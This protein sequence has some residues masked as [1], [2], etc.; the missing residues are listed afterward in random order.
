MFGN[1]KMWPY[2]MCNIKL[3]PKRLILGPGLT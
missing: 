1:E 3:C 2:Y